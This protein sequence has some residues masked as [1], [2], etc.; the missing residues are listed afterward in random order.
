MVRVMNAD[1][2]QRTHYL[3]RYKPDQ[4]L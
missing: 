1:S 4:R 2:T 3:V